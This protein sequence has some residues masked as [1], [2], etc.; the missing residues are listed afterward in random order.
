MLKE[1]I[2]NYQMKGKYLPKEVPQFE[3][4]VNNQKFENTADS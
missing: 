4:D 3:D 2:K 1:D